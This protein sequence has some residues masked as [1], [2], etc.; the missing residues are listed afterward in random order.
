M[1]L[2]RRARPLKSPIWG[3]AGVAQ[4]GLRTAERAVPERVRQRQCVQQQHRA[5]G[6]VRSGDPGHMVCGARGTGSAGGAGDGRRLRRRDGRAP[7]TGRRRRCPA[8][9]PASPSPAGRSG[10]RRRSGAGAARLADRRPAVRLRQYPKWVISG[11]GRAAIHAP[12]NRQADAGNRQELRYRKRYRSSAPT[13]PAAVE[14]LGA[15]EDL[16]AVAQCNLPKD[17]NDD[18]EF[19]RALREFSRGLRARPGRAQ[20]GLVP[21]F[22][23]GCASSPR[24]PRAP[25][26]SRTRTFTRKSKNPPEGGVQQPRRPGLR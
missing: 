21:A 1:R 14:G 12:R 7:S 17:R 19:F 8:T 9:S 18:G 20:D 13:P 10:L 25:S 6:D 23:P 15:A 26:L 5:G 22:R 2:S 3:I 24:L 11:A 16:G 4:T